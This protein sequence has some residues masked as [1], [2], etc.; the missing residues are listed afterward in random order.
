MT[1]Y[2]VQSPKFSQ[3][4]AKKKATS[5]AGGFRMPNP[6]DQKPL[7]MKALS[8]AAWE[9]DLSKCRSLLES[10]NDELEATD[11]AGRTALALAAIAGKKEILQLLLEKKAKVE[12]TDRAGLTALHWAARE[13][14][15]QE[16]RI[17]LE[18]GSNFEVA[19]EDG[20][21]PLKLSALFN[22]LDVTRLL[23]EAGAET[24]PALKLAQR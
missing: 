17:L 19:D 21:T 1:I 15:T 14:R 11:E 10:S 9:G 16:V 5:E 22:H 20:M 23:V 18:A 2:S 4:L 13:G 8:A 24:G 6:D 12:A 3:Y 7:G